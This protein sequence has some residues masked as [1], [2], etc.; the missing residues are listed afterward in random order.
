MLSWRARREI[1][2]ENKLKRSLAPKPLRVTLWASR[3]LAAAKFVVDVA[4]PVSL[5]Y[6]AMRT[7]TIQKQQVGIQDS[8]RDLMKSQNSL[9]QEQNSIQKRMQEISDLQNKAEIGFKIGLDYNDPPLRNGYPTLT[10]VNYGAPLHGISIN[11]FSY[12]DI[13]YTFLN[14]P[15]DWG[16]T[17]V[18]ALREQNR[19]DILGGVAGDIAT[20]TLRYSRLFLRSL[21]DGLEKY[22]DDSPSENP[23]FH[24]LV[25]YLRSFTIRTI[26]Q[27]L[28]KHRDNTYTRTFYSVSNGEWR[29]LSVRAAI[30][31]YVRAAASGWFGAD[32]GDK[33][34]DPQF[35]KFYVAVSHASACPFK[36]QVGLL[37]GRPGKE[38]DIPVSQL[39]YWQDGYLLPSSYD[40]CNLKEPPSNLSD[41]AFL[42]TSPSDE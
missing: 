37:P 13:S 16:D 12:L 19:I 25:N 4:V 18:P 27:V 10:L 23:A 32:Y 11:S 34:T 9:I 36:N 28:I 22:S 35:E 30:R 15:P 24:D 7:D 5:V 26:V 40:L 1:V 39:L 2:E 8:Q 42:K 29:T 20:V 33:L 17:G 21:Q 38:L 3:L 31:E 14:N 6:F 41:D